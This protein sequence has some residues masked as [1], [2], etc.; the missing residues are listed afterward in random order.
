L[1]SVNTPVSPRI[2]TGSLAIILGIARIQ[3]DAWRHPSSGG[4]QCRARINPGM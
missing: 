1:I 2:G 4:W 3:R